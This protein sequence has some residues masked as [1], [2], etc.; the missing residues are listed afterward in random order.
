[1]SPREKGKKKPKQ[2]EGKTNGKGKGSFAKGKKNHRYYH[3]Q[4]SKTDREIKEIEG[5]TKRL[6]ELQAL[7]EEE[8][9][10]FKRFDQLPLSNY[11]KQGEIGG[12][13]ST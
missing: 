5:L 7:P 3:K 1:M 11:T 6:S 4:L 13:C 8:R 12:Q 10:Q 9:K 2:R